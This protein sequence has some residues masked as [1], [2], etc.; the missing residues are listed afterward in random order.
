MTYSDTESALRSRDGS[1]DESVVSGRRVYRYK[2]ARHGD[3]GRCQVRT[4]LIAG[5]KP[6]SEWDVLLK[7]HL[8]GI[9]LDW[10]EFDHNQQTDRHHVFSKA[11]GMKS[12]RCGRGLR[13]AAFDMFCGRFRPHDRF[14][15]NSTGTIER[16]SGSPVAI[17]S[18]R[19]R[20]MRCQ[21]FERCSCRRHCRGT[22]M[23]CCNFMAIDS[24]QWR[25][26]HMARN[27]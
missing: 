16:Q 13:L 10:A 18:P 3:R 14:Q 7:D 15:S 24:A 9:D 27:S 25:L 4:K 17:N 5:V 12:G 26:E 20:L 1:W 21:I 8:E 19:S 23:S 2:P 6:M 11:G 22:P